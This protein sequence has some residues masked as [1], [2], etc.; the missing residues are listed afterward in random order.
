VT[1]SQGDYVDN[2]RYGRQAAQRLAAAQRA[3]ARSKRGSARRRRVIARVAAGHRKVR[4]QRRNWDHQL[5]R[6]LVND[7]DL[8]AHENLRISNM[9]RRPT[10]QRDADGTHLPNRASAKA[11]L[12]RSILDA[13][14]GQLLRL[15]AYKAEEAGRTVIAVDAHH[16]SQ[17]CSA[18]GHVANGNRPTQAAFRCLACG[19]H[20]HAD[21]NAAVNILRAGL[22]QRSGAK[23]RITA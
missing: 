7:Y 15:I 3:L 1:T 20:A 23:P 16:T 5:S 4:N 19:H 6:R 12:N 17:T 13:G 14:W 2:P 8:I 18:C 21:V 22:A 10:P 11:G 9:T